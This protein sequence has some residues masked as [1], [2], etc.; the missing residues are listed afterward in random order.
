MNLI[1]GIDPGSNGGVVLRSEN[2]LVCYAM[3]DSPQQVDSLI[4]SY[5]PDVVIIE[6]STFSPPKNNKGGGFVFGHTLAHKIGKN[7]GILI[8]ILLG[9]GVSIVEVTPKSWQ[10]KMLGKVAKGETK[11]QAEILAK[12]LWP[13]QG[14][15]AS[16]RCRKPHDGMIDAALLTEYYLKW[17]NK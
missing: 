3:P 6:Q 17:V 4:K 2:F 16:S 11:K 8:G 12:K 10:S 7:Y 13:E 14:F 9:N 1:M 5:H 15:L